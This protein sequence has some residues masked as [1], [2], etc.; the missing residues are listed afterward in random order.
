MTCAAVDLVVDLAS[1]IRMVVKYR[2]FFSDALSPSYVEHGHLLSIEVRL[3]DLLDP[4]VVSFLD[5]PMKDS[6]VTAEF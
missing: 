5:I 4:S 3:P 1:G 2:F 6:I